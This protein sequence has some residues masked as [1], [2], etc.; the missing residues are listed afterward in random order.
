M[1]IQKYCDPYF[2]LWKQTPWTYHFWI[3]KHIIC[4][5]VNMIDKLQRTPILSYLISRAIIFDAV[6]GRLHVR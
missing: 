2:F 3:K 4:L 5:I 1:V 6:E